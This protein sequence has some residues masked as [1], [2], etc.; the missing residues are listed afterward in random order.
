MGAGEGT[1]VG[2]AVGAVVGL[3]DGAGVGVVVGAYEATQ[4][5]SSGFNKQESG[6]PLTLV[7]AFVG[8]F[9]GA[10]VG[11]F[12]GALLG[13]CV[14]EATLDTISVSASTFTV[15]PAV[16][17]AASRFDINVAK[18]PNIPKAVAKAERV[19]N[20]S[21]TSSCASTAAIS[22]LDPATILTLD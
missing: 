10:G 22:L 7:G 1:V 19:A 20:V 6:A 11:N 8:A 15:Y 17:S 9:V 5:R 14:P 18:L 16:A 4:I 3:A 2:V 13:N 21:V 12:V